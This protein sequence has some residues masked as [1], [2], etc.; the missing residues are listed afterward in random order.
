RAFEVTPIVVDGLLYFAT[1]NQ[2]VVA[3]E[4]ETGKEVW[5]FDPKSGP[6]EIRGVTYWPG[7]KQSPARIFFGTAD[8]R[9]IALDAK[10]G[11]PAAGFGDNGI[12]NLKAGITD[13]FP[14]A[15]YAVSS[16]PAVYRNVLIVGPST[17]EGPS[18]GPSGDPRGYDA[19][20]GK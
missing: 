3:L 2:K 4:P 17:Q 6:R 15:A 11:V 10:T 18:L 16:P 20:T 14:R 7:E 19:R 5:K 13:K 1:Q 12:V 9:L 8:G